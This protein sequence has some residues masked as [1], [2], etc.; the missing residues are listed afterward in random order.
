MPFPDLTTGL[1]AQTCARWRSCVSDQ[2]NT[3][4]WALRIAFFLGLVLSG[5]DKF[6]HL[7]TNWDQYLSPMAQRMLGS[8]GHQFT[9]VAGAV[10]IILGLLVI[11]SCTKLWPYL[12]TAGR[13]LVAINLALTGDNRDSSS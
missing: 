9:L 13:L 6:F 1:I 8:H 11:T 10:E 3:A 2:T 5:L 12:S 4:W 7:L